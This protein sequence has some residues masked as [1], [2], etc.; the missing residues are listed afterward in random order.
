MPRKPMRVLPGAARPSACALHCND[1]RFLARVLFDWWCCGLLHRV[2][3]PLCM[4]RLLL[5]E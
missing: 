1:A 4:Q 2:L 5:A 3:K